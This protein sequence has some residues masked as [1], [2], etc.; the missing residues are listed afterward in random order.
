MV[1]LL[2]IKMRDLL[3]S[4]AFDHLN[5]QHTEFDQNFSKKSNAPGLPRGVP[6]G[7]LDGD[8]LPSSPNPDP[9]SDQK[10]SSFTSVFR[11]GLYE[12]CYHYLD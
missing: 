1:I 7:I 3:A 10:M 9:I 8:V 5:R 11:P 4:G 12:K 6:L 2:K